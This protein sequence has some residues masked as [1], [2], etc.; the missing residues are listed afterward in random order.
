MKTVAG[1]VLVGITG[2][3][4]YKRRVLFGKKQNSA[5][6]F[7]LIES[8]STSFTPFVSKE[9]AEEAMCE[10]HTVKDFLEF[11]VA[12]IELQIAE[13]RIEVLTQESLITSKSLVVIWDDGEEKKLIGLCYEGAKP[14]SHC[15]AGSLLSFNNFVAIPSYEQALFYAKDISRQSDSSPATLAIFSFEWV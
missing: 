4:P 10:L 9:E 1:Y 3:S 2:G 12:K 7:Q 15:I 11:G 8:F 14:I 5:I 6:E 13:D